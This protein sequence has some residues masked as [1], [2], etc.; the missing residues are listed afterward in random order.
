MSKYLKVW[1]PV[2]RQFEIDYPHIMQKMI[3]WYPSGRNEIT[4]V[5]NDVQYIYNFIGNRLRQSSR[6]LDDECIRTEQMWRDNFSERLIQ[7][8]NEAG[9]GQWRLSQLTGISEVSLSRYMNGKAT[10]SCYNVDRIANALRCSIP[11][12]TDIR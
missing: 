1:E 12:L 5:T 4:I 6:I 11:E 7:K 2:L 8:M 10:P 9:I 3:D